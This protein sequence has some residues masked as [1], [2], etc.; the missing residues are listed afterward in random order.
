MLERLDRV[1]TRRGESL[2]GIAWRGLWFVELLRLGGDDAAVW[3]DAS[4]KPLSCLFFNVGGN[5]T[6]PF[7]PSYLSS[8]TASGAE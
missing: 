8:L 7:S 4:S 6:G 1:C 2:F 3:C 5:A